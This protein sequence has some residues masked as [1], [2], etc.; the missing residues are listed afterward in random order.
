MGDFGAGEVGDGG[1]PC[2]CGPCGGE[3]A[4][5]RHG[6][7]LRAVF[8][9]VGAAAGGGGC[10]A[11][12]EDGGR[13]GEDGFPLH[14]VAVAEVGHE[15]GDGGHESIEGLTPRGRGVDDSEGQGHDGGGDADDGGGGGV[16]E[17]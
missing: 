12:A 5:V 6:S 15:D 4:D 3:G 8:A 9:D 13:N 1:E 10:G 11:D 2:P 16:I 17:D 7:V 14:G